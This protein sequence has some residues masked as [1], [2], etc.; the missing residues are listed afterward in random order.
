M[1]LFSHTLTYGME[2][3]WCDFPCETSSCV[4]LLKGL[5]VF[6]LI[7]VVSVCLGGNYLSPKSHNWAKEHNLVLIK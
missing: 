5:V 1:A 3:F 6:D 2:C 7:V 4:N